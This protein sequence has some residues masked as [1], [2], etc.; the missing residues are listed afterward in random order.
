MPTVSTPEKPELL[1]EQMNIVIVGHV[2]HGKSTVIGRLM[3]DT[4]SLPEGKLEA[5]KASCARN[6]RPFEY[7]FLLDALKDEQSQGITIDAARC[8][9][10]TDLRDY[11]IIDAPGHIEFLKNM[12]TGAAR[13]EA[14]L[15]VIDAHEGIQENSMRHGYILSMLGIRQVVVLVNKMDLVDYSQQVFEQIETD[16]R[17]FLAKINVNPRGFVPIAAREGDNIVGPSPRLPWYQGLS[18]LGHVDHF[19]KE[20]KPFDRPFRMP[21]QDIY[22]FTES[23]DDRR[24]FAGTIDSGRIRVGDAVVFQPS[25]KE[26]NIKS[27]EMFNVPVRTEIEAGNATGF[28]LTT[29]I[30]VKPG[31]L[32]VRKDEPQPKVSSRF[33]ANIFWMGRA[34]LRMGRKYKLKLGATRTPVELTE[35]LNVIDATELSRDSRKK[36]VDRHDVAECIFE[37]TKPIAFDL[38]GDMETT[39]RFVIVDNYEI[40]GGGIVIEAVTSDTST[41][42]DHIAHREENWVK[43]EIL[44]ADR[45]QRYGHKS[46]FILFAGMNGV[47]K[48]VIAHALEKRLFEE[49]FQVYYLSLA[50]FNSGFMHKQQMQE[51]L[52][53]DQTLARLGELARIITDTGQIFITTADDLD[54]Y[55][56]EVLRL[57]NEPNEILVINVGG[58]TFDRLK[59]DLI[60]DA[61]AEP[62]HS[63][64]KIVQLMRQQDILPDYVI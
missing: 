19:Q 6:A 23:N 31:E 16:Y 53:K 61:G 54:D 27:I 4:G 41:L 17:A 42:K 51:F 34:P 55:D 18:V 13:A 30:Y 36:Q 58:V 1:K 2:D 47:G 63:V 32:M 52:S 60:L 37:T 26:A 64:D 29:Q 43:G 59:P 14:A 24:I 40:A 57:L 20:P 10:K 7:A 45:Q 38:F 35:V 21:L 22:K 62:A 11:I 8:F 50:S 39:G 28:Q 46:K 48:R 49:Q 33:K 3:A 9:F 56:V 15:L 12:I 5:V 44:L 25:G